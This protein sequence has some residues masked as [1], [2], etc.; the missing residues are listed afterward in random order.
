MESEDAWH[1]LQS[2]KGREANQ[3]TVPILW[4]CW[5]C[6]TCTLLSSTDSDDRCLDQKCSFMVSTLEGQP[7]CS[8]QGTHLEPEDNSIPPAAACDGHLESAV[9]L[10]QHGRVLRF[11]EA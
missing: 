9:R 6:V 11:R 7:S 5:L 8:M 10:P 1:V 3:C 2:I 4:G